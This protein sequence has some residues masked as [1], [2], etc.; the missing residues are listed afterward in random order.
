VKAADRALAAAPD[1]PL[2]ARVDLVRDLDGRFC[3]IELEL[4]EPFL[5]LP[6]VPEAI[7][8]AARVMS[9]GLVRR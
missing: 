9:E 8:R 4:I 3:V 5:F 7:E 6:Q 2:Y 1:P